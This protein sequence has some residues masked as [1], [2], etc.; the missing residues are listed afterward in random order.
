MLAYRLLRR[1]LLSIVR[2]FYRQIE[3]VG[4]ENVPGEGEGAVIFVGNHPNS[5][6]DPVM[7]V[8]T[9][10]RVVHFA[11]KDVLF[12][13]RLLRPFLGALG[14][15]PIARRSDHGE[16]AVDNASAFESLFAVMAAG[17]SMG[18]FPEGLSHDEAQVQRLKT[19]AARIALGMAARHPEVKLQIIP[20]GLNYVR[21]GRFRGRV[22]VQYGAPLEVPIATLGPG[23]ADAPIECQRAAARDLTARIDQ[24]LRA[25]TINAPDW[26]TLRLLDG[27]RRLYQPP[28]ISLAQRVELARRFAEVY[29]QVKDRPDVR[30]VIER[31]GAYLDR[32]RGLG[33]SDRELAR[34]LWPVEIVA[35]VA[36]NLVILLVWLPLA[37]PG[38]ILHAPLGLLIGWA[39]RRF[40]PRPD[41]VATAKLLVGASLVLLTYA[42][43]AGAAAW[44][45]GW[46]GG[47]AAALLLPLT[48]VATVRTL[49]RGSSLRRL[50]ASGLRYTALKREVAALRVERQALESVIAGLV[51]EVRPSDM[52]PLFPREPALADE[53]LP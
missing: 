20:C 44:T 3:V 38:V 36:Q 18:I 24:A 25:L 21:R 52:A 33:L 26:E 41:V 35:K 37:L 17:R 39:G 30:A 9:C 29:P 19:G 11:A 50:L 27:V 13:S 53:D 49:E 5:L 28:R 34:E 23:S 14:A 43:I 15:V 8:T 4:L 42:A 47:L 22:L 51:D 48:G 16:G 46:R 7:V 10:G 31:V 1:G 2:V 32:L 40:A 6:L 12:R 45:A